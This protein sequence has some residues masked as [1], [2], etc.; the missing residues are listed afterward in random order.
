MVKV[1][2]VGK[3]VACQCLAQRLSLLRSGQLSVGQ[4]TAAQVSAG[5]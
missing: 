2:H 5:L 3:G 4:A 1:S